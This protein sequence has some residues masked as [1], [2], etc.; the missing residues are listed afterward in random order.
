M[1]KKINFT[2]VLQGNG[3]NRGLVW[4]V[5]ILGALLAFEIFNYSTTDF[6]MADLLGDLRFAGIRWSTILA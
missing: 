2:T 1:S 5:L 4:G 6:A 3:V